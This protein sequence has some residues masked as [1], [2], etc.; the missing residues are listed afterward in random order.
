MAATAGNASSGRT[1]Y[2]SISYGM[3]STKQ[4]EPLE[5]T[6]EIK[7]EELKSRTMAVE[8]IDLRNKY[9][10][11]TGDY[12]Y[13]V[14]YSNIV[15]TIVNVEKDEY[16]QGIN[17][18]VTLND[19]DGDESILQTK[20]YGKVSADFLNR[21]L[22]VENLKGQELSFSPYSIPSS[23]TPEGGKEVKFYQSGVSVKN[24]EGKVERALKANDGL[25]S[26]ERVQN[27]E[28]QMVTSRVKQVNFLWEKLQ[29]NLESSTP[30]ATNKPLSKQEPVEVDSLP[31]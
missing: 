22:N 21:L 9:V 1:N 16:E 25:P 11:K 2:Y 12:P 18:R 10:K 30:T 28:G 14:F 19:E 13:Q 4:K 20:F 7:Q 8:N 3:L 29:S 24:S 5:G 26:S 23:Y 6:E 15:G 27:A 31:F 17:L